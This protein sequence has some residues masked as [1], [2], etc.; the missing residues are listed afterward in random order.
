[1]KENVL[2][3][4]V[5]WRGGGRPEYV[6]QIFRSVLARKVPATVACAYNE[7]SENKKRAYPI[8]RNKRAGVKVGFQNIIK[9][10]KNPGKLL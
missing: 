6:I 2:T 9:V 7:Q 10:Y 1:M 8:T 4:N 5:P 3:S